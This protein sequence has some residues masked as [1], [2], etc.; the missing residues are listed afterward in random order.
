MTDEELRADQQRRHRGEPS[1]P[2]LSSRYV[3]NPPEGF[4]KWITD[5]ADRIA[6]AK[7]LPYYIRQNQPFV[8]AALAPKELTP[9]EIAAKRHAARTPE[10]VQAIQEAWDARREKYRKIKLAANNVLKVAQDYGEVDYSA[11]KGYIEAGDLKRMQTA[12]RSTAADVLAMKKREQAL[13]ELIPNVHKLHRS[14]TMADLQE[15]YNDLDVVMKKWLKKYGYS[16]IAAAPLDHLKNKLDFELTSPTIRYSQKAIVKNSLEENIKITTRKI[17]WNE[18]LAKATDLAAFKTRSSVFKGSVAKMEDAIRRRDFD[19]LRA[20]IAEAEKQQQRLFASQIKRS[21][22]SNTALNKE[23]KGGVVGRDITASFDATKTKSED[24]FNGTFTNNVARLQGFDSPAKLVSKEEFAV[25]EK[26]CG[27]VFYRTVNPTKFKGKRM[28]GA[29]FAKQMYV[30]DKLE[31]NGSG[32]RVYG[33][34]IYVA[35]SAWDGR[36]LASSLS[37]SRKRAAYNESACY[38]NGDY[39]TLE[40]TW[41]RKPKM[42]KQS[43]L[44]RMWDRLSVSQKRRFGGVYFEYYANTYACALGYDGMYCD[45]VDY[46]VIWNRSI[47]AVKNR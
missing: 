17:E 43:D 38:G 1:R 26:A 25:L 30:A 47:I 33:D 7:S 18:L 41:T 45:G 6:S 32:G 29:E 19:A 12:T 13:S 36:T 2:E 35:S 4:R 22:G 28:S 44:K 9:L 37:E 8:K 34:G 21:A 39:K 24:P 31:M 20:G 40:M 27:D 16:S 11:L 42:I 15:A 10:Q 46:M 3:A 14:Y 5:H 23:Y